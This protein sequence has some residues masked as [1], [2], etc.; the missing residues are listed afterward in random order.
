MVSMT[1]TSRVSLDSLAASAKVSAIHTPPL[2]SLLTPLQSEGYLLPRGEGPQVRG[3]AGGGPRRDP[4]L[5]KPGLQ[6]LLHLLHYLPGGQEGGLHL[7]HR[8]PHHQLLGDL[9][10]PGEEQ[11][12]VL[13]G[14][15]GE[16][17][18]ELLH[19]PLPSLHQG[20]EL[21]Q[22]YLQVPTLF[23]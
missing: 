23:L 18:P 11:G 12:P 8:P 14:G 15:E 7:L 10:G 5:G 4:L 19:I 16:P 20:L 6:P 21:G 17:V 1:P 9:G 22:L 2:F 3:G 13:L